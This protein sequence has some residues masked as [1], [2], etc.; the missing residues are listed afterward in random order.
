MG[1]LALALLLFNISK[2][3][4]VLRIEYL[5]SE[6]VLFIHRTENI[7]LCYVSMF[8]NLFL[9]GGIGGDGYK[10]YYLK[11]KYKKKT[12]SLLGAILYDRICGLAALL[13][14]L[15]TMLGLYHKNLLPPMFE[16][17]SWASVLSIYPIFY[18]LSWI[19]FKR[20]LRALPMA[21]LYSVAVQIAQ[22]IC[23]YCILLG[24]GVSAQQDIYI[25][26]FLVSSILS[27]VPITLGGVGIREM[28]FIFASNHFAIEKDIAV[29]FGLLFFLLTVSSSF[30]GS[31]IKMENTNY[32]EEVWGIR[33]Q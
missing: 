9:P 15:L 32:H 1:W 4:S 13:L 11:K 17:L 24:L 12:K 20:F 22:I 27:V 16:Y 21:S 14:L 5:F 10:V 19:M 29:A 3:A 18:V 26:L 7:K 8:Y 30:I 6:I 31:F 33:N 28:V 2:V 25:I 23:A